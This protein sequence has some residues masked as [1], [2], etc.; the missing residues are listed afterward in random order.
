[1]DGYGILDIEFLMFCNESGNNKYILVNLFI[2]NVKVFMYD[3]LRSNEV[4]KFNRN[5]YR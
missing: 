1:M 5:F 3:I 4:K 2:I